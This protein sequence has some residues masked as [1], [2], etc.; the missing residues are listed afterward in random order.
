VYQ[1]YSIR[2]L[3]KNNTQE[4]LC[5]PVQPV[6]QNHPHWR[7]ALKEVSY[8]DGPA[9]KESPSSP[10][11]NRVAGPTFSKSCPAFAEG[12]LRNHASRATKGQDQR[13]EDRLRNEL[14]FKCSFRSR[15]V[16]VRGLPKGAQST[17]IALHADCHRRKEISVK[18]SSCVR[19][20]ER[21]ARLCED[22][23]R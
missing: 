22:G 19:P 10:S 1:Q 4:P 2:N 6:K 9:T 16:V 13:R 21:K 18:L 7:R 17:L 5:Q 12:E 8:D 14:T 20:E 3:D 23:D 15:L 11:S